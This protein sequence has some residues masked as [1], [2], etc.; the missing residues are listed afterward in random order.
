MSVP[1]PAVSLRSLGSYGSLDETMRYLLSG[2]P[3]R[4]SAQGMPEPWRV[5]GQLVRD[6]DAG[7]QS[8][9]D[10]LSGMVDAG[11]TVV[12]KPNFVRHFNECR[13]AGPDVV[14][15]SWEILYPLIDMAL[16]RVG[17]E[18]RVVLAD[19]PMHDC[20][21][22][23]ILARGRWEEARGHYASAGYRL[24]FLDL[25]QERWTLT[26]GVIRNRAPLP[27]DPSGYVVCDLG[28]ES[29]FEGLGKALRRL[30]GA[31]FDDADTRRHHSGGRHEYLVSRTVLAADLVINVAKFKT[32][33]KIGIT[34]ATKNVVGI[35][36][37]KNWLPH[38][39]AGFP[40]RGGDQF[41]K[42]TTG[43]L[44]RYVLLEALWPF[45]KSSALAALVA[46]AL[47]LVHGRGVRGLAGGGGWSG[48][49][50][51]WRM[52]CD[53]NKVLAHFDGD[54]RASAGGLRRRVLHLVDAVIA[55]QGEGPLG[56]E[57]V[58]AGFAGCS[59]DPVAL[60]AACAR[61]TG[62]D[63]ARIPYIVKASEVEALGFTSMGRGAPAMY[64]DG[65]SSDLDA[66]EP[67]VR[68]RP[69]RAWIGTVE[70]GGRE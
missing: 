12:I 9:S 25:R 19:A 51:T 44:L 3:G 43:A 22:D 41:P 29:E 32:H 23:L 70:L 30:R 48:N 49:D 56:P 61:M 15:T 40:G 28:A 47:K 21:P 53:L 6:I 69:A 62:L 27:G 33:A 59:E 26:E 60:D 58:P 45:M 39:R 36:G 50:T 54:G 4:R 24:D 57:P 16:E 34:S 64:V 11:G 18:G 14:V 20:D 13:D 55:G 17:A 46:S 2:K 7:S 67:R 52:V 10:P 35:N 5:V 38:W 8:G 66:I 31:S 63:Y 65:L 37:N 68:I 42:R 1:R